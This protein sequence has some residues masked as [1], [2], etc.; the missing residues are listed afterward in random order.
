MRTR[1]LGNVL[2]LAL[3]NAVLAGCGS[4][5]S[6][7][8]PGPSRTGVLADGLALTITTA[9][10]DDSRRLVVEFRLE[11][12]DDG[13]AIA[14]ADLDSNPSFV[15]GWVEVDPES[16]HTR[17]RSSMTAVVPGQEY[18]LDGQT[19]MP[20]MVSAEQVVADTGGSMQALAAGSYRY[21]FGSQLPAGFDRDA[22]YTV[23]TWASQNGRTDVANDVFSFVPSKAGGNAAR[24]VVT[25][26]ACNSCHNVL[27]FHGGVRRAIGLCVVCHTDQTVDPETG[28]NLDF[29]FM[30][31]KIHSGAELANLPYQ[32][33]G[34]RQR[35]VDYSGVVYPRDVRSCESCHKEDSGATDADHWR[36]QPTRAACGGCHDDVDFETGENHGDGIQ[37]FDDFFCSRC[38]R[39]TRVLDFDNSVPGAHVTPYESSVNPHLTLEIMAV[40][41]M[42]PGQQ[43][44]VRFTVRDDSGAVDIATLNRAAI[45]FAGPTT[46]YS[47][48]ISVS[49]R[50]TIQGG[51][52]GGTLTVHDVGDYTYAP[53]G[54]VV[55][56]DTEG[57]W[58]V[59]LEA[60]T[61]PI[62]AGAE[63]V[64]F[65]A[66][67]PVVHVDTTDGTLGGGS[68][69]PRREVVTDATCDGC[70]G[71]LVFHGNLR[72]EVAYCLLCHNVTATDEGRRPDLDALTNPP[73]S[74]DFKLMVH[75]IHRGRDLENEYTVF[76]FGG[77]PAHYNEIV[78]PG[79]L[80]DCSSCHVGGS[81]LLP[82]PAST[83]A[84]VV[85]IAGVPV[86]GE[87][88]V[89]T[90]TTAACNSCHDDEAAATHARLNT[91][92]E[93]ASSWSE[94]CAVCHGEGSLAAVGEVHAAE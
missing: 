25:V 21:R 29:G 33:V 41:N 5:S 54:Y 88:A 62:E 10:V 53:D 84:T 91:I 59:G 22:T 93:D 58:S 36:T 26:E 43:P 31:H 65:G 35:V 42:T 50:F 72:T 94:S 12:D 45:V 92:L 78:F 71:D 27:E 14:V 19:R 24:E 69:V 8:R 85:N 48:L 1:K 86:P 34:F 18:E 67:N 79:I 90:P 81:H 49:H 2:T 37:Q 80:E 32:I 20:A 51:G 64:E 3:A 82:G 89:S 9:R 40:E 56:V 47:Q 83:T 61:E 68:P 73:A 52:A 11:D 55:P 75:K 6:S 38:H 60:R 30:V 23:A 16:G 70:H 66:N 17:Y 46:D 15:A 13:A 76:G 74:V 77:R 7:S 57:T 44:Q 28:E 39:E 4:S 63:D 87:D